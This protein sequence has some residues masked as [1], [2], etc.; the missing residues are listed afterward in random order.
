MLRTS[1]ACALLLLALTGCVLVPPDPTPSPLHPAAGTGPGT[2]TDEVVMTKEQGGRFLAFVG[3]RQ[4]HADPFLGVD[5]TN[6]FTLRS[7]LDTKTGENA[8][9]V[10]VEDSYFGA[11]Y[12]WNAVRE[13]DGP[14]LRFVAI[15]RNQIS[16]EDGCSYADEFAAVV[17][18]EVLRA[19]RNSGLSVTFG[20]ETGK[21]LKVDVPARFI[22]EQL[23]AVDA[24]RSAL[25]ANTEKATPT[26][27]ATSAPAVAAP[28]SSTPPPTP[29]PAAPAT[30]P[31][32][33][34][35]PAPGAL[36]PAAAPP[37]TPPASTAAP[38]LPPGTVVPPPG[39]ATTSPSTPSTR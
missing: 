16:C 4:Q 11:P 32:A 13:T 3:P 30:A 33:A 2:G 9:Q 39:P 21:S 22:A 17:P 25:A 14:T 1:A 29:A 23:A 7:W 36:T 8:H 6:Y 5:D 26:P 31:P 10:Y 27:A 34:A 19:H 38:G 12:R 28:A 35:A 37:V 24:A 15:S 20:A 18:E